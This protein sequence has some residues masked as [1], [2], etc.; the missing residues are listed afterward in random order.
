MLYH[1][2]QPKKGAQVMIYDFILSISVIYG[3]IV[4]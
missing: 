4:Y 1:D 2:L 3:D